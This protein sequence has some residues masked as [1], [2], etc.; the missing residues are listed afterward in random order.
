MRIR[1][2]LLYLAYSIVKK[3]IVL[4]TK[5]NATLASGIEIRRSLVEPRR[6]ELPTSCLQ[7]RRSPG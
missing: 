6:I 4:K 7:S 1:Y 3:R 2:N 5:L